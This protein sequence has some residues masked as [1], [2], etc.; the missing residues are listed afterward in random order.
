MPSPHQPEK[1]VQEKQIVENQAKSDSAEGEQKQTSN[2]IKIN[3]TSDNIEVA[4]QSKD[5][6]SRPD[7]STS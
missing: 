3:N 7:N 5:A 2:V 4:N 6:S 1:D